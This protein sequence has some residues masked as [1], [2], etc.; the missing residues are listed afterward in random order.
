MR[1][2]SRARKK[3]ESPKK[4]RAVQ[5]LHQLTRPDAAIVVRLRHPA[6]TYRMLAEG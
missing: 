4:H 2:I 6:E 3:A 5:L 1:R